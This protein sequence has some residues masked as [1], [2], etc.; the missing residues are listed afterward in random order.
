MFLESRAI[1]SFTLKE[2]FRERSLNNSKSKRKE[3]QMLPQ[4][5]KQ[6]ESIP[7]HSDSRREDKKWDRERETKGERNF[8]PL[9]FGFP[10]HP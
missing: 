2:I 10:P 7:N 4:K 9:P 5:R 3:L 1:G 6:C 8:F